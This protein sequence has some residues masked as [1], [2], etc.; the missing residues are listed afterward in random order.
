MFFS[1]FHFTT[2][3]IFIP[4]AAKGIFTTRK[5]LKNLKGV[6]KNHKNIKFQFPALHTLRPGLHAPVVDFISLFMTQH[7]TPS[8]VIHAS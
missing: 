3:N 5:V 1:R 2:A 7:K 4:G 8:H 6:H